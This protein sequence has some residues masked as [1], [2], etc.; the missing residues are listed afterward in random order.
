MEV[1]KVEEEVI[2]EV[3]E[4]EIDWSEDEAAEAQTMGWIPPDRA[5][6]LPEG[7]KFIGP[8]EYM[9]RN[10]LYN[11]MKS[12][13]TSFDQLNN[14]YHKVSETERKKAEKEYIK[15]IETLKAEK[16]KALDEADHQRVVDIDEQIRTTEKPVAESDPVF[17]AWLSNNEWY[18][19]DTFLRVEADR[20]AESYLASGLKGKSLLDATHDHIKQV[21]PDKFSNKER[22]RPAQVEGSTPPAKPSSKKLSVNNLTVDEKTVYKNFESM[23]VFKTDDDKQKYL[24]EVIELRD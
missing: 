15:E 8:K 6:K 17:D 24:R 13:E 22:A 23:N 11:K 2:E 1:E 10:P 18:Q 16:I 5:K 7:K 14:H 21:Y 4:V 9:E 19:N 20:I 12:L 3:N